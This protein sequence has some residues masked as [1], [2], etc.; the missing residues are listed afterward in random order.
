M[1]FLLLSCK[2]PEAQLDFVTEY[3]LAQNFTPKSGVTPGTENTLWMDCG[4]ILARYQV[5]ISG[6]TSTG[7]RKPSKSEISS[8][9]VYVQCG[10]IIYKNEQ[11]EGTTTYTYDVDFGSSSGL[12][13]INILTYNSPDLI[14]VY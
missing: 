4:Q 8:S 12:T 2:K 3:W 9:I 10:E 11:I 7:H 6:I 13:V 5:T 14:E 1:I